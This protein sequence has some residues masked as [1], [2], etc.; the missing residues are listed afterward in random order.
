MHPSWAYP[1]CNFVQQ[2]IEHPEQ[3]RELENVYK[4]NA[5]TLPR[6]R[7]L[8]K[9]GELTD[10]IRQCVDELLVEG[11]LPK[12]TPAGLDVGRE[13]KMDY[14]R[15]VLLETIPSIA[16]EASISEHEWIS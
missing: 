16:I 6:L 4:K 8:M 1:P 7:E 2:W 14:I 11:S 15:Q 5:G 12:Y 3:L 10:E 13:A 9:Q